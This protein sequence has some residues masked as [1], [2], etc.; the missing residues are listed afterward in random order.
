MKINFSR[1]LAVIVEGDA[2]VVEYG[3]ETEVETE[4]DEIRVRAGLQYECNN[5]AKKLVT[6]IEKNL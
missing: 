5:C 4:E 1:S 2:V 3:M 6:Y